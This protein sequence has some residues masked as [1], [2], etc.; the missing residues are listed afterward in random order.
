M[1]LYLLNEVNKLKAAGQTPATTAQDLKYPQE[2]KTTTHQ[3]QTWVA[4]SG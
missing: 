4:F 1:D 2:S 3:A